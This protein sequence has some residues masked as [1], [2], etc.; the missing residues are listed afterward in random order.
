[1]EIGKLK[2]TE[3]LKLLR[4]IADSYGLNLSKQKDFR[5]ARIILANLYCQDFHYQNEPS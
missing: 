3:A 2:L 5:N 1:M 4:P